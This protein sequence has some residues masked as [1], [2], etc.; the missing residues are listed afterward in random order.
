M[1]STQGLNEGFEI[2]WM[3][4]E[5]F[6]NQTKFSQK[7]V[8]SKPPTLNPRAGIMK[9]AFQRLVRVTL[10]C[11]ALTSSIVVSVEAPVIEAVRNKY[12]LCSSLFCIFTLI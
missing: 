8:R 9:F 10:R 7:R 2:S 6:Y 12:P 3:I 1:S 4:S 11:L 5:F